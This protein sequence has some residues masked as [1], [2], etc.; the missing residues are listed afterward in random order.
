MLEESTVEKAVW[1]LRDSS[2]LI[3]AARGHM[4]YCED[5]LRRVKSLQ[6]IDLDGSV[7]DREVRAY[8]SDA[9][10][11]AIDDR[12]NATAEY[13]TLRAQRDAAQYAIDV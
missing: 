12:K 1:F 3:G 2:P 6:M 13:E 7:A 11:Q 9:Y 4:V 10:R 8:A 5:N